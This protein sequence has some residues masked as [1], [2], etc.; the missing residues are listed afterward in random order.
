M[1]EIQEVELKEI[2]TDFATS[3]VFLNSSNTE[4][5]PFKIG[6]N[7]TKIGIQNIVTNVINQ[8]KHSD[9]ILFI[10]SKFY[11]PELAGTY[12]LISE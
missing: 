6:Q 9:R 3:A 4:I 2:L 12:F 8:L 5:L 10:E 7:P 1:K 11:K